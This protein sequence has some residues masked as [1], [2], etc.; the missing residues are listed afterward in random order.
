MA[1][2]VFLVLLFLDLFF[3]PSRY[4]VEYE[5]EFE[6]KNKNRRKAREEANNKNWRL[7]SYFRI[8]CAHAHYE[9]FV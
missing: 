1:Y 3:F 7:C 9:L 8:S 2:M 6:K 4:L 5:R